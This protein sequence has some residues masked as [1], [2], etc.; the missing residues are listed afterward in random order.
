M[1]IVI[2]RDGFQTLADVVIVDPT[3]TNLLQCA[4]T[5]TT[6]ATIVVAQDKAR[7]CTKANAKR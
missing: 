3:R 1:D 4:L 7:S 2:T 5:T 6:H